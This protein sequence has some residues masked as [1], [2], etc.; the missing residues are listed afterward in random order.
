MPRMKVDQI[1]HEDTTH[2]GGRRGGQEE[3]RMRMRNA[4]TQFSNCRKKKEK[5]KLPLPDDDDIAVDGYYY[6][7]EST[8]SLG[9]NSL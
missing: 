1:D 3:V 5:L 7:C 4:Q 2:E 8:R 9:Q 6:R